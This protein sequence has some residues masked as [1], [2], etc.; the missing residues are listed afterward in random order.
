MHL[1]IDLQACQTS[2]SRN[3]GIG[4]Y[5]LSLARAMAELGAGHH[6]VS[7]M[8]SDRFPETVAELRAAFAPLVGGENVHLLA[9]PPGCRDMD[10]TNVGRV[11]AAEKLRL[12]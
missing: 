12:A 10:P 7:V 3:R 4:R 5:S 8:L 9:L 1:L 2:G 11:V 6:R